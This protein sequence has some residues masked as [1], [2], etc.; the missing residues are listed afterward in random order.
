M[1]NWGVIGGVAAVLAAGLYVLWGPLAER[2]RR[3]KGEQE[4]CP[5]GMALAARVFPC[6]VTQLGIEMA[7]SQHPSSGGTGEPPIQ[8]GAPEILFCWNKKRSRSSSVRLTHYMDPFL[9]NRAGSWAAQFGQHVLHELPSPRAVGMSFSHSVAG[10]I[11][12]SGLG[13][14]KQESWAAVPLA[15]LASLAER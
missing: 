4:G 8:P 9:C 6:D 3:R 7:A 2:K 13:W 15:D 10:R 12:R 11:R 5:L 1:R 14:P